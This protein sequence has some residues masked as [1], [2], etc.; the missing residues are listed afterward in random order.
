MNICISKGRVIDPASGTDKQ[1]SLYLSKGEIVAIGRKPSGFEIKKEIDAS[2]MLVLPGLVDLNARLREPGGNSRANIASETLA[3]CAGGVTSLSCPPDTDPVIDS[4]N[5]VDRI[6]RR[7][8]DAAKAKVYCQGAL[9]KGLAGAHLAQM[10]ALKSAGC[11]AVSNGLKP[12]K[13]AE[14]MR[15]AFEYAATSD[16]TVILHPEDAFLGGGFMH[17]GAYS[18]RMGIEPIPESAE[19][20]AIARD[21]ILLEE[22]GARGHFSHLSCA[23]SVDMI[24]DAR[25]RGIPVTADVSI[26][27]LH[28]T[29]KDA[30]DYSSLS[31]VIPPFRHHTDQEALLAGLADGTISAISSDHH[32]H[33]LDEKTGPF[34]VTEPGVSALDLLLPLTWDLVQR[35]RLSQAVALKAITSNP[36]QILGLS[37]GELKVGAS[38]DVC[39]FDPAHVWQ[40]SAQTLVSEGKNTPALG[41][42]LQGRVKR[43]FL[44][45]KQVYKLSK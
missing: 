21:L 9:T 2:G 14:V 3:A 4:T 17:E 38:A 40:V 36:A 18:T 16:L 25:A 1:T 27:H 33:D 22:T 41:R 34:T 7:V 30:E 24:R 13:D 11:V 12:V 20:V 32:P 44:N 8:C 43:T 6:Q 10:F 23:R 5:V 45:G 15:R 26:H 35:G 39:L 28:F 37:A 42:E 19:M 31:H 29:H